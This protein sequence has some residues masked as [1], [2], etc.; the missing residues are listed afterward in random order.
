LN[1][2]IYLDKRTVDRLNRLAKAR[3]VKRN[4]LIREAV[5]ALLESQAS[6]GWPAAVLEHEGVAVAPFEST[7][8]GLRAPRRDTLA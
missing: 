6:R 8:S 7:R 3:G 4:A 1:F 2:N 5:E